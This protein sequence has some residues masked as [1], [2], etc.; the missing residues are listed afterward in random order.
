MIY[1][2]KGDLNYMIYW[3]KGLNTNQQFALLQVATSG[4][5]EKEGIGLARTCLQPSANLSHSIQIT[6]HWKGWADNHLPFLDLLNYS[7]FS[8]RV[9]PF[10]LFIII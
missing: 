9:S 6:S 8:C 2:R 5:C 1:C 4:H 7:S 3:G 10:S